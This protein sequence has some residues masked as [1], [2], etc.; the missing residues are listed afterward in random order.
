LPVALEDVETN[1]E[2]TE[3]IRKL[4]GSELWSPETDPLDIEAERPFDYW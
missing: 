1:K 2:E 4:E 3:R